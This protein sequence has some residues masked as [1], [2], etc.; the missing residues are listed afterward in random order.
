MKILMIFLIILDF[1]LIGLS[2]KGN[3]ESITMRMITCTSMIICARFLAEFQAMMPLIII[4]CSLVI[5]FVAV[6]IK[7]EATTL[8][9]VDFIAIISFLVLIFIK[10]PFSKIGIS[11]YIIAGICI[12]MITVLLVGVINDLI[13]KIK[14]D[15]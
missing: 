1:L 7:K 5:G 8:V 14:N 12:L 4:I 13:G 9:I 15:I 2:K 11:I 3:V 10:I 6:I